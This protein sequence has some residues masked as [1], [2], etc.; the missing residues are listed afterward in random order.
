MKTTRIT[1][2]QCVLFGLFAALLFVAQLIFAWLPNIELVSVMLIVLARVYGVR[3]L[4]PLYGFVFLEGLWHGFGT[5]FFNYL[6]VW[7]PLVLL[8]CV[9]RRQESPLFWAILNGV[10]GLFFG[11]LCAL[12]YLFMGGVPMMVA[13]WLGGLEF[14]L[15]HCGGNF[16]TALAL[17]QPLY[18]LL[19]RLDQQLC[20]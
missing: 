20:R 8:T 14:D 9:F 13:Y 3:T 11:A 6:Y 16:I 15:L 10:F 18:R 1:L 12:L 4:Y 17:A 5:W 7:L 19:S 2:L